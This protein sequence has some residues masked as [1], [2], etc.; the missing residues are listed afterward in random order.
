VIQSS[1]F[2]SD[3]QIL[4]DRGLLSAASDSTNFEKLNVSRDQSPSRGSFVS[5][6]PDSEESRYAEQK[7]I[8]ELA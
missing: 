2:R 3:K 7:G 5:V 4:M 1:E 6:L 8:G